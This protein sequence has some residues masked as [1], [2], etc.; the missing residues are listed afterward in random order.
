MS[1]KPTD[2][3]SFHV[4]KILSR[5][6]QIAHTQRNL[7]RQIGVSHQAIAAWRRCAD[8]ISR[9]NLLRLEE[10]LKKMSRRFP[11][12]VLNR[13]PPLPDQEKKCE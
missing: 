5:A 8:T 11:E 4:E 13:R 3:I 10:W 2:P 7:A 6:L 9:K 12:W 1:K